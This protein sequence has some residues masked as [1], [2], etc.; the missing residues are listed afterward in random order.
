MQ[1]TAQIAARIVYPKKV[2]VAGSRRCHSQEW[3]SP[4]S[5]GAWPIIL[6]TAV[7][8]PETRRRGSRTCDGPGLALGSRIRDEVRKRSQEPSIEAMRGEL[9]ELLGVT[10][11][12]NDT[13][14]GQIMRAAYDWVRRQP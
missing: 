13:P 2:R 11:A 7:R 9:E 1:G 12:P 10:D 4:R 5:E 8:L 3:G 6:A 14:E